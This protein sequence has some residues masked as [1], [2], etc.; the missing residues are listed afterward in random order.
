M[1]LATRRRS[2]ALLSVLAGV[3]MLLSASQTAL[4]AV[5]WTKPVSIGPQY[6]W[7]SGRGLARTI[8]SS[9]SYLHVQY[10]D[11]GHAH[12]GIYYRRG[13]AAGTSW[14]TAKRLNPSGE[15]AEAG[16]IAAASR[17]VYVV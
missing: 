6:S 12:V 10:E 8:S 9:T 14:G 4:A 11:D 16:A 2:R 3:L 7:N 5:T 1:S 17:Y 13:N 15:H